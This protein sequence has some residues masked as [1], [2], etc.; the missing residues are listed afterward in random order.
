VVIFLLLLLCSTTFGIK[1]VKNLQVTCRD[2]VY[3]IDNVGTVEDLIDQLR[4]ESGINLDDMKAG[5]VL[6]KGRILEKKDPLRTVGVNDGSTIMVVTD[7]YKMKGKEF[8]AL[9]LN[10][11]SE[12]QWNRFHNK[13]QENPGSLA[14]FLAEWK[15][16]QYVKRD[17][18]SNF[19]RNGLDIAYH[20][21]K[22]WWTQPNFRLS[23]I[24]P[25]RIESY[26]KVVSL[27]LNKKI[28]NDIGAKKVVESPEK[29]RKNVLNFTSRFIQVGD[30]ILDGILDLLL[31]ILKGAGR[32]TAATNT[33]RNS[34]CSPKNTDAEIPPTMDD[35]FLA[36]NLLF[37]L[38][39][40]E[41][42]E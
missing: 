25:E 3:T 4:R 8:L 32:T 18:V 23:L 15:E 17:D 37:E 39:E 6:Y 41:S 10:M 14:D 9:F 2:R 34:F 36:N 38:S 33:H 42:E 13:I 16:A 40:S 26:R 22:T 20:A 29:W 7:N 5:K 27:H 24:D 28:L 11:M 30:T 12:D 35:P 31:D 19:L 21:L 1:P